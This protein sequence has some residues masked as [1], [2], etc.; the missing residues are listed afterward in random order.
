MIYGVYCNSGN[1]YV[2]FTIPAKS[3]PVG[4]A[5]VKYVEYAQ[6]TGPN[7]DRVYYKNALER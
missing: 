1:G 7:P 3:I 2:L 5:M 6:S 4:S